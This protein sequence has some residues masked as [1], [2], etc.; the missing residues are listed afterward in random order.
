MKY[1]TLILILFSSSFLFSQPNCNSF[2]WEGDTIKYNACKLSEK[3]VD[4]Y[5][6]D[7]RGQ[8][9][10]DS[11]IL[12][13]PYY[14]WPYFEKA[15]TYIKSGN[16]L[17]WNYYINKSYEYDPINTLPY[18]ASCRAKF[19][20]DYVGAI[21]DINELDSLVSFDIGYTNG[22]TYH[23]NV[24]KGLCYKNLD[25]FD[26]A[27]KII[28]DHIQKQPDAIGFY[29]YLHLGVCYQKL[30]MHEQALECFE[31]QI[32]YND[33]S[34]I[35]YYSAISFKA[36]GMHDEYNSSIK[37]AQE[38]LSNG[39]TLVGGFRTLD[40]EIFQYELDQLISN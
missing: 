34:E 33:L 6:F 8:A 19:F 23:L 22:G 13:C 37:K 2:L 14:A 40:D 17:K 7:M 3:F 32:N 24:W 30:E 10:L 21:S 9:I 11:C 1:L 16:F 35:W 29:D 12:I 26:I 5:Q 28:N 39:Q 18:R 38:Y 25:S 20:A 27:A 31:K 36:L 15:S 4:Y